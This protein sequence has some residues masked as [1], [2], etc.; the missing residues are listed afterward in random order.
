[1]QPKN[2]ARVDAIHDRIADTNGDDPVLLTSLLEVTDRFDS[3]AGV[4]MAYLKGWSPRSHRDLELR[5]PE[6]LVGTGHAI[7]GDATAV[8]CALP[9]VDV[10]YVDPP[11]NQYRYFTNYHVWRR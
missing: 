5:A 10:A 6:L 4:Q 2:G 1:V 11:Y 8:A 3:T 9:V 7:R